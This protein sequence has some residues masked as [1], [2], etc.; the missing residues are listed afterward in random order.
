[1]YV[2]VDLCDCVFGRVDAPMTFTYKHI[3][4]MDSCALVYVRICTGACARICDGYLNEFGEIG[5]N[6]LHGCGVLA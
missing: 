5:D 3:H 4:V 2:C 1:M 6:C